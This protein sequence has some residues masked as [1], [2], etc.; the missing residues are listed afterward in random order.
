MIAGLFI[1]YRYSPKIKPL[2][3]PPIQFGTT[4]LGGSDSCLLLACAAL[5]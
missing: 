2:L 1:R 3:N 5:F 4:A